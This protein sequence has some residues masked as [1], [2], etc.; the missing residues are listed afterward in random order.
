MRKTLPPPKL[1]G[2]S[3]GF[4]NFELPGNKQNFGVTSDD[5]DIDP[6]VHFDDETNGFDIR[7]RFDEE[8]TRFGKTGFGT[9]TFCKTRFDD[10]SEFVETGFCKT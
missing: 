3:N 7:T 2:L 6:V 8:A 1:P 10:K 5:I 4:I 9:S